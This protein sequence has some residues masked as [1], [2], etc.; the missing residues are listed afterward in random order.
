M[1]SAAPLVPA[2]EAPLHV[3]VIACAAVIAE[4]RGQLPAGTACHVVDAGLH[5]RPDDLRQ[6]LQAAIDAAVDADAVL[7]AYGRCS[8]AVIGLRARRCRLVIPRVDDCIAL[9]LGS[10]RAAERETVRE[11]GTYFLTRGWIDSRQSPL[12]EESRLMARHGADR[13]AR[14]LDVMFRNYTRLAYIETG[15]DRTGPHRR[16]AQAAADRLGLR[17][18]VLEGSARLL[19][20]LLHGPWDDE[21]VVVEPGGVV[22][23]ERFDPRLSPVACP[24]T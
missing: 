2:T 20:R 9:F 10:R 24:A 12:D 22:T 17:F 21:V 14:L 5:R 3:T 19:E 7:L 16:H 8:R 13:G 15:V 6:A 18:E 1:A 23:L 11:P 4:L